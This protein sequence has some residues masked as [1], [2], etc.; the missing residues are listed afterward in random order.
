MAFKC[1]LKRPNMQ[2]QMWPEERG[3]QYIV[4]LVFHTAP[5]AALSCPVSM[6][7]AMN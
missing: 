2:C 4:L 1:V 3:Q 6:C 7:H 5:T